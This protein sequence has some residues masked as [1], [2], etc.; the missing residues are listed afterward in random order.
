MKSGWE[1][2]ER[3]DIQYGLHGFEIWQQ[4]FGAMMV[5]AASSAAS[6]LIFTSE[7]HVCHSRYSLNSTFQTTGGPEMNWAE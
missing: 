2:A 5:G 7:R 1:R 4:N 3:D 6:K